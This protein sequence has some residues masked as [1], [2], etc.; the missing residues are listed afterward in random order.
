LGEIIMAKRT[1]KSRR[2]P[3]Q[4]DAIKLLKDD[5]A[6]VEKLFDKYDKGH[7]KMSSSQKKS[8]ATEICQMLKVHTQ[9]EEEIFY[10]ACLE[11]EIK[12]AEDQIAEAKV[13][14]QS[15][16][17]L[18]AKIEDGEPGGTEY[19]A[20]VIVLGE[21][22]KHHVKEEHKEM[23]PAVRKSDLD[24]K[25]LGMRLMERKQELMGKGPSTSR[26][27]HTNGG[28]LGRFLGGQ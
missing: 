6:A 22:I 3:A 1:T 7:H 15:A 12:E 24:L 5:H 2:K 26:G 21:Y 28:G 10:P 4:P 11:A 13:E 27:K 25:D 9:I 14:H 17:D 18:I 20:W 19:D 16:K 8:L 23:F